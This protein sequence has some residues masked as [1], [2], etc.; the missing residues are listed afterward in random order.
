MEFSR[1]SL[2]L[3]VNSFGEEKGKGFTTEETEGPQKERRNGEAISPQRTRRAQRKERGRK[4][5]DNAEVA[6]DTEFAEE[7]RRE[8]KRRKSRSLHPG[9]VHGAPRQKQPGCRIRTQSALRTRRATLRRGREDRAAPPACCRQGRDD[10][11]GKGK[12]K[13][14]GTV[15]PRPGRGRRRSQR[16]E[17]RGH[18]EQKP[19]RRG[20]HRTKDV[21]CKTA[22][23]CADSVGNDG[24]A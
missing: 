8:E 1:G 10:K 16:L 20:I 18:R 13:R 9:E 3:T 17:H 21:R 2:Q 24:T 7:K 23:H 12:L 15:T 5:K 22:P 11:I 4:E 19:K 6:E 14:R